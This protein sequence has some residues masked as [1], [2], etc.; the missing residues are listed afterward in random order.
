MDASRRLRHLVFYC[1]QDQIDPPFD[2]ELS[3]D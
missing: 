2:A 1:M 3:I